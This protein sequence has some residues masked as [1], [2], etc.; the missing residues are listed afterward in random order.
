ME[1]RCVQPGNYGCE[2]LEFGKREQVRWCKHSL[3]ILMRALK[4]RLKTCEK[5]W[6]GDH[7]PIISRGQGGH[8]EHCHRSTEPRSVRWA[9]DDTDKAALMGRM[10]PLAQSWCL[11]IYMLIICWYYWC[12][13][14]LLWLYVDIIQSFNDNNI[15]FSATVIIGIECLLWVSLLLLVV[16]RG[17][18]IMKIMFVFSLVL[19]HDQRWHSA[20]SVSTSGQH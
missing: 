10:S 1:T 12:L 6:P 8:D 15:I 19:D 7:Q 11:L 14:C 17:L 9:K 5:T 4:V 2:M 16:S 20:T 3:W 18:V 13:G